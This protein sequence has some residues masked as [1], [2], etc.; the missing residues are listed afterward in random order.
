MNKYELGWARFKEAAAKTHGSFAAFLSGRIV[1]GVWYWR[2][3][4]MGKCIRMNPV[5]A[6]PD[7][8]GPTSADNPGV[9]AYISYLAKH[10]ELGITPE[11]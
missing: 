5:T 10:P 11:P 4:R 1:D 8:P 2:G 7:D 6:Y 9:L 3:S